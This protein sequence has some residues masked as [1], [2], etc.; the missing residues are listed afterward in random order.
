MS[1]TTLYQ[2]SFYNQAHYHECPVY[3]YFKMKE[4][5]TDLEDSYKSNSL[6]KCR[7]NNTRYDTMIRSEER[8]KI[9]GP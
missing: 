6:E 2:N 9:K 5:K 8:L 4:I 3:N 1:Q 7:Y